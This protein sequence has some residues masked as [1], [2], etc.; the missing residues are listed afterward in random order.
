MLDIY[1]AIL[2]LQSG[3]K[4]RHLDFIFDLFMECVIFVF[5]IFIFRLRKKTGNG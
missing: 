1:K 5:F 2:V 3:H 4:S